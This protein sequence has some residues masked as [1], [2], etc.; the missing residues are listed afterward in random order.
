MRIAVIGAGAMG[1]TVAYRLARRGA[2]V[3]VIEKESDLGGLAA[4]FRPSADP[5]VYLEKAYHHVFQT[6]KDLVALVDELGL[7]ERLLWLRPTTSTIYHSEIGQLD[8]PLTVL[9][10][11]HL[12]IP[13]R[14][15]LAAGL[16]YLKY[17]INDYHAL[18][19]AKAADWIQ[20]W[21]GSEVYNMQWKPLLEGKFHQFAPEVALPWFWSRVKC[22]TTKLGY[23]KGGFQ[24]IY[25]RLGEEITKAGGTIRM[26]TAVTRIAPEPGRKVRVE[27][28]DGSEVYDKVIAT[29]PT[30]LFLRVTDGLPDDYRAKYDWGQALGAHIV[31]LALD[32]PLMP[33][34]YWL[35]INDPGYPFLVACEHTNLMPTADYGGKHLLYLGNYLPMDHR[36]FTMPD[37]DV[38]AEFLPHL[39]KLN[40]AFDPSWVTEQWV[41]KL[42]FAQPVVTQDFEAHIPPLDTPI[43]NLYLANMFQVYPQDRGQNYSIRLGNKLAA[44]LKVEEPTSAGRAPVGSN[45]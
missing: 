4:G 8:S 42:P 17:L 29:L 43:P 16:G 44:H 33:P 6:D 35:N 3:T 12:T 5:D 23:M 31:I 11:K 19:K 25:N 9:L 2:Q 39:T 32:K 30:R 40:P 37:A 28:A 36:Y 14:L 15:R 24:H 20:Q 38:V 26:N 22:R 10:Y 41:F 21:M 7:T 13:S 27:T 45:A 34:V 1:L 18:P